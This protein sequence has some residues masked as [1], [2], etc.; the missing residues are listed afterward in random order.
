MPISHCAR[1]QRWVSRPKSEAG[2]TQVGRTYELAP[3]LVDHGIFHPK[4]M[5]LLGPDGPRAVIGS[6]NLTF[7][8]WGG[9]LELLGYLA[10]ASTPRAF[11]D[12]ADFF[13]TLQTTRR[14]HA[15]WPDL[16]PFAQA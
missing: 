7:N 4:I 14:V 6:G 13:E 12:L 10:P 2:V 15:A 11:A 16:S 1:G 3:V 5:L 9:N 8:G